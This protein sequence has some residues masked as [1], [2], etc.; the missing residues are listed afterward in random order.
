MSRGYSLI[1]NGETK[2]CSLL[3]KRMN[4]HLPGRENNSFFPSMVKNKNGLLYIWQYERLE[5]LA[6]ATLWRSSREEF[7]N[8]TQYPL[9]HL[10]RE[11]RVAVANQTP[12]PKILLL[13]IPS[14]MKPK[15]LHKMQIWIW[16][17]QG[18]CRLGMIPFLYTHQLQTFWKF[19]NNL[20][21]YTSCFVNMIPNATHHKVPVILQGWC[22]QKDINISSTNTIYSM[23]Q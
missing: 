2:G 13:K 1:C 10:I 23:W 3:P 12:T 8:P 22:H 18:T 14:L 20:Q 21:I 9:H 19:Y 16:L 11:N 6:G 4:W 7:H 15:V 17:K 5:K